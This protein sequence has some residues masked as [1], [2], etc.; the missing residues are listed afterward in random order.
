VEGAPV[1]AA[2]GA[3]A[4]VAGL[5]V[6]PDADAVA[7][8]RESVDAVDAA[9]VGRVALREAAEGARLPLRLVGARELDLLADDGLAVGV[10]HAAR[11]DAAA[12]EAEVEVDD[13][14]AAGEREAA[15]RRVA[16]RLGQDVNRRHRKH[17]IGARLGAVQTVATFVVGPGARH[18][19]ESA[20]DVV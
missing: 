5:G 7:A 10:C 4:D 14:L 12:R 6:L 2:R 20:A 13:L 3:D 9:V 8:G 17:V 11:D 15:A 16:L 19:A 18:R 1:E